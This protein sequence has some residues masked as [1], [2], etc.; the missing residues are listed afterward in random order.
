MRLSADVE[1]EVRRLHGAEH[2]KVGTIA[3]QLRLH[4]RK[5]RRA[6][7]I[8]PMPQP[9]IRGQMLVPYQTHLMQWLTDYPTLRATRIFDMLK[10]RGFQGSISTVRA[11]VAQLRPKRLTKVHL[12]IE[13][14]PGEQAQVDWAH[15]GRVDLPGGTRTMWMFVMVLSSSRALWAELVFELTAASLARSLCRAAQ[16]FGG[17]PRTWLFDNSKAVVLD[18]T[19]DTARLHPLL[20]E[21]AGALRVQPRLCAPYQPNH[22][23]KVERAI[24]YLRERVLAGRQWT[25]ITDGNQVLNR[26]V[27]TTAL[28]REHPTL[29]P[30][31]VAAVLEQERP[32]LLSLP[33]VMPD[34]QA[35]VVVRADTCARV[36]FD[37]N[38]YSVPPQCAGEMLLQRASDSMVRILHNNVCVAEHPRHWGRHQRI[39]DPQ[40]RQAIPTPSPAGKSVSGRERLR[41]VARVN[42][43][44]LLNLLLQ[45]GHNIGL[46]TARLLKLLDLYGADLFTKALDDVLS[47]ER[48]SP[49]AMTLACETAR[50]RAQPDVPV[51]AKFSDHV[52]D[53]DVIP[54]DL[55]DYDD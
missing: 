33:T 32:R 4:R 38:R 16:H 39:Y 18:R 25:S 30:L 36:T 7:G 47:R 2:W 27:I 22:K 12:E 9:R 43:D 11:G 28:E 15:V 3:R 46:C 8:E 49:S 52:D 54:H 21:V 24:R 48:P 35:M 50:R 40:H 23:G 41:Q 42:V 6:L 31:T 29:K 19:A 55:E 51:P 45:D 5:V 14:L 26:F 37:T 53:H 34:P 10:E 17:V 1:A 20:L 44:R 13:T